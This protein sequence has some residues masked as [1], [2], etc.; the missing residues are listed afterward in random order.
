MTQVV[1]GLIIGSVD[2][3]FKV[4]ILEQAKVTHILNVASELHFTERVNLH[5]KKVAVDDD[6]CEADIREIM[7]ESLMF[8]RT[9]IDDGGTVMVHCLEGKS[10]SACVVLA[11]MSIMCKYEWDASVAHL[12]QIRPI[13]DVFPLYLEQTKNF[14]NVCH[15]GTQPQRENKTNAMTLP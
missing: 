4:C 10:R 13:I 12:K 8:I 2:E 15:Q 3:A 6:S 5:Y 1:P 7:W 11:Y 9:A 14:I